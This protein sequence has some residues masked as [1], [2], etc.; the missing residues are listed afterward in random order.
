[1]VRGCTDVAWLGCLQMQVG[2]VDAMASCCHSLC[3]PAIE[4]SNFDLRLKLSC[5]ATHSGLMNLSVKSLE[6]LR[7]GSEVFCG[8]FKNRGALARHHSDRVYTMELRRV[9]VLANG[10]NSS[11]QVFSFAGFSAGHG[12]L[13]TLACRL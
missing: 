9:V 10:A 12:R 13:H 6:P 11:D 7:V 8:K 4:F 3:P 1:M 2:V 5:R